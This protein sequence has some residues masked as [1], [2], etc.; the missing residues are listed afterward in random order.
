[1]KDALIANADDDRVVI[2][3][4]G[5][6]EAAVGCVLA[7]GDGVLAGMADEFGI[8]HLN[9]VYQLEAPQTAEV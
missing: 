1:M 3:D 6:L 8:L 5:K 4:E 7:S 2:I 9:D